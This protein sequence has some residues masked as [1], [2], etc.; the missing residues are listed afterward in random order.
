M[1]DSSSRELYQYDLFNQIITDLNLMIE[2][3]DSDQVEE[4]QNVE[5]NVGDNVKK[6]YVDRHSYNQHEL[7][8]FCLEYQK[9]HEEIITKISL[10][11]ESIDKNQKNKKVVAN[12]IFTYTRMNNLKY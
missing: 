2:L 9:L 12:K 11:K 7:I 6:V 10:L 3:L 1:M 8:R 5:K 4:T